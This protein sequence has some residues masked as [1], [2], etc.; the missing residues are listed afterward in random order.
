MGEASGDSY[1]MTREVIRGG[2]PEPQVPANNITQNTAWNKKQPRV[3]RS[4][5]RCGGQCEHTAVG[6]MPGMSV[7]PYLEEGSLQTFVIKDLEVRGAP[8]VPGGPSS[9][10]GVLTGD[11]RGGR[12]RKGH[13]GQRLPSAR[14][15]GRGEE[16]SPR[17]VSMAPP[18][19]AFQTLASTRWGNNSVVLRLRICANLLW[20]FFKTKTD[21]SR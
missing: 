16:G 5:G 3:S 15:A 14:E 10:D 1:I 7:W 8:W 13:V 11:E 20:Q 6:W 21:L 4:D 17:G 12:C 19:P 18:S 2:N 9:K